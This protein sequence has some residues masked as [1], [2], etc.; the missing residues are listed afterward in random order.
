MC[1]TDGGKIYKFKKQ[2][3]KSAPV[4]VIVPIFFYQ[5]ER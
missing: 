2:T 1:A 3:K 4:D 5:P